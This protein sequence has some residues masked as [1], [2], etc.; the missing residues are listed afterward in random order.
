MLLTAFTPFL[1]YDLENPEISMTKLKQENP[2]NALLLVQC[3]P[4]E[5]CGLPHRKCVL[6]TC[7]VCPEYQIPDLEQEENAGEIRFH[8]YQNISKC[9]AHS[10]LP[11]ASRRC[12][13]CG[14][15]PVK[16]IPQ[17]LSVKSQGII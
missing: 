16:S 3:P 15:P 7:N 17:K 10:L 2:R 13:K 5:M 11:T 4:S 12:N 9:Y 14:V 8:M 1:P 6:R